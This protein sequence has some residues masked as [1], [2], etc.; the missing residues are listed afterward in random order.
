MVNYI[1]VNPDVIVFSTRDELK[2]V[3]RTNVI[4]ELI[5]KKI[6]RQ[7]R[8]VNVEEELYGILKKEIPFQ[9]EDFASIKIEINDMHPVVYSMF[10]V[11]RVSKEYDLADNV[12]PILLEGDSIFVGPYTKDKQV[13]K[14]Y[15][16]NLAANDKALS[17]KLELTSSTSE[18]VFYNYKFINDNLEKIRKAA[19]SLRED[20][21][22]NEVWIIENDSM[23]RHSFQILSKESEQRKG[24]ILATIDE[25]LGLVTDVRVEDIK[26]FGANVYVAISNTTDF[27]R[28]GKN[29]FAQSNSGAGFDPISAK[30]SAVGESL[31]RFAGGVYDSKEIKF[32]TKKE[33]ISTVDIEKF[34]LFSEKQYKVSGFPYKKLDE[35][36]RI[37]WTKAKNLYSK[38]YDYV[39]LAFT[40]LPYRVR[41]T[42]DR[43][44]PAISTGLALGKNEDAAILSGIYEVLER[45]AFASSWFMKL[46]PNEELNI[47]EYINTREILLDDR[48]KCRAYDISVQN[49]LNTV[50]VTIH[51]VVNNHFMIGAA[52][53]FTRKEA[54]EKAFIEAAQG[55]TYINMLVKNYKN[56]N[57][58]EDFNKIDTFQKHAAFYSIYP[59]KQKEVGY[60]LDIDYTF[61][62]RNNSK[63]DIGNDYTER[64]KIEIIVNL[65]KKQG[66]D[67]FYVNMNFPGIKNFGASA[68]R[69]IIPGLQPLHGAHKYRFLDDR[70]LKELGGEGVINHNPHPFP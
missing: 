33:V 43:I 23:S 51:D 31:E 49:L 9:E 65:L 17:K 61:S 37:R 56:D 64:E 60:L 25:R 16:N 59:E 50:T 30:Y 22:E 29:M 52:T 15:I 11:N 13:F 53:R 38:E 67:V 47:D 32:G 8:L 1:A 4:L 3:R 41:E 39:P 24:D 21:Y 62:G 20:G 10:D 70:R 45:D 34:I 35:N 55:I 7:Q 66:K 18:E 27:G 19:H 36:T 46:A 42:E 44:S 48:Y 68:A 6:E 69:V 26:D 2:R 14:E 12:L 40:Q 63:F 57:L 58:I 54:V 28:F 5:R